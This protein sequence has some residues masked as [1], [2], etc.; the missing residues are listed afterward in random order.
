MDDE[1]QKSAASDFSPRVVVVAPAGS[2]KTRVLVDHLVQAVKVAEGTG[3]CAITFTRKAAQ[4]MGARLKQ[5][6]CTEVECSTIHGLAVTQLKLR[7]TI[8]GRTEAFG[9]LGG[10]EAI[11]YVTRAA[12][13]AGVLVGKNAMKA[14]EQDDVRARYEHLKRVTDMLD[15]DDLELGLLRLAEEGHLTTAYP[16]VCVDEYQ[17]TS[18]RQDEI[19][20][21]WNPK[22]R[23]L[24]G[25]P[26]QSIYRFRGARA[27]NILEAMSGSRTAVSVHMLARNYRSHHDIIR[28]SNQIT[29]AMEQPAWNT[30]TCP[31]PGR[32]SPDIRVFLHRF[33]TPEAEGA[34]V[35]QAMAE[36]FKAEPTATAAVLARSWSALRF[37]E[38][39]LKAADVPCKVAKAGTSKWDR[40]GGRLLTALCRMAGGPDNAVAAEQVA[41]LLGYPQET[42]DR[43]RSGERLDMLDAGG[44]LWAEAEAFA[45]ELAVEVIDI[46]E[47]YGQ[48]AQAAEDDS[49]G[50]AGSVLDGIMQGD[51]IEDALDDW[52]WNRADAGLEGQCGVSDFLEWQAWREM[53]P[54]TKQNQPTGTCILTTVHSAKGLE[55][56]TVWIVHC[57]EGLFPPNR[58]KKDADALAE[59]RRLFYVAATRARETLHVSSIGHPVFPGGRHSN[60]EWD[61]SRFINEVRRP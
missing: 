50:S 4:E 28:A 30:L 41:R 29:Q 6:G 34:S 39:A 55:W 7:P 60:S 59:E 57:S 3:V 45:W 1:I 20:R 15:Y 11:D 48:A 53:E 44:A 19:L 33:D 25:D 47:A 37:A 8:V 2:G 23:F 12:S 18:R 24:V 42:I 27:E 54:A 56:D 49:E 51:G 13:E 22:H 14:L 58:A 38:Q 31:P 40:R 35:A 5:R 46:S 32:E 61:E 16:Y 9:V 52:C 17:D 10:V 36:V 26:R 21:A 43:A